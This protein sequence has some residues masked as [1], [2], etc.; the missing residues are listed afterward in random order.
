MGRILKQRLLA[1]PKMRFFAVVVILCLIIQSLALS[2]WLASCIGIP[3]STHDDLVR[4]TK[5][6]SGAY[7][8][9]C[10]KPMGNHLVQSVWFLFILT[11]QTGDRL[12]VYRL[13]H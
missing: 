9:L 3:Q 2:Q 6:S 13:H 8:L 1:L 5:Y 12:P 4:Y 10:L 7:H 11:L